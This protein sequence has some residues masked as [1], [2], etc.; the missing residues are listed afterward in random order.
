M[1]TRL[2]ATIRSPAFSI[3]ALTAPV[4]LRVVASG[5]MIEKVRSI[6]MI[7]SLEKRVGRELRAYID[8]QRARQA[9]L[10]RA[11]AA[12]TSRNYN[13]FTIVNPI[14]TGHPGLVQLDADRLRSSGS[15]MR[16]RLAGKRFHPW[17]RSRHLK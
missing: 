15:L 11:A 3:S 7:S 6:A 12:L 10:K 5:L 17:R 14:C 1:R 4:R 13:K 16:A 2:C 9:T 8:A